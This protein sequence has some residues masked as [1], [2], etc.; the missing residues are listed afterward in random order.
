MLLSFATL[1]SNSPSPEPRFRAWLW[2]LPFMVGFA[3]GVLVTL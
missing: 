3:I 2:S 1:R